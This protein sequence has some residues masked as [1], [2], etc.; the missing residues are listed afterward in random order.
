MIDRA[1]AIISL[2][3]TSN[4]ILRNDTLEWLDTKNQPPTEEE[5]TAEI[6][7]LQAEYDSKQYQRDRA[8]K[9]P[10]LTEQLDML[11]HD[12][13][14]NTDTWLESIQAVKNRYPKN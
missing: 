6:I 1:D 4:F 13:M 14:N 10:S 8:S 3:P 12:K 9:Y 7:R 5:I 11:Y 2:C